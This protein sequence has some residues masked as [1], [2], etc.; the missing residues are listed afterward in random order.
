MP[1]DLTEIRALL[2]S[3]DGFTPG[4][5]IAL[6]YAANDAAVAI[7][8]TDPDKHEHPGALIVGQTDARDARLIAAAPTLHA[9]LT[10]LVGEVER[11]RRIV[12]RAQD[13]VYA[14]AVAPLEEMEHNQR[15][16]GNG[17]HVAQE[18]AV[19]FG[20]W[21]AGALAAGEVDDG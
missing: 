1:A 6:E 21:L 16:V 2:A 4:P 17:H 5:W 20:K 8:E 3:V 10:D 18:I 15:R 11:L 13:A 9:H 12:D 19:D 7:A 14:A